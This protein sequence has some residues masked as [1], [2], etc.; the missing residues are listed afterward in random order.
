MK[1]TP[2]T[3]KNYP[4]KKIDCISAAQKFVLP[5][6]KYKEGG[7]PLVFPAGHQKQGQQITDWEGKAVGDSGVVFFNGVDKVVQAVPAT[8]QGIVIMNQVTKKQADMLME[9]IDSIGG[10]PEQ[11][12]LDKTKQV[13]S[14]ARD[15][16]I[17]DQY[18]SDRE[19]MAAKFTPVSARGSVG[20]FKRDDRDLCQATIM[21]AYGEFTGPAGEPQKFV[22]GDVALAQSDGKGG[23]IYAKIDMK[24]FE[25]TYTKPDGSKISEA[26]EVARDV[27][28][29]LALAHCDANNQ[30]E[31]R[32]VDQER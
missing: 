11:F 19:F 20:L 13:L 1:L 10:D 27:K 16:G 22:P 28:L 8:G 24:A 18:N 21:D 3:L 23:T 17:I 4:A 31:E 5:I 12:D 32:R 2:E 9:K 7:E 25:A 15:I 14:Y 30:P 26:S 29:S 6:P